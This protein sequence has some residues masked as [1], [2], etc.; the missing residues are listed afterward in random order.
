M[1]IRYFRVMLMLNRAISQEVSL[2]LIWFY[3]KKECK[4]LKVPQGQFWHE[5]INYGVDDEH[6]RVEVHETNVK[7]QWF[8]FKENTTYYHQHYHCGVF[9]IYVI[10]WG[11]V[12]KGYNRLEHHRGGRGVQINFNIGNFLAVMSLLLI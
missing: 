5:H 9:T 8:Q 7:M 11:R 3:M 12:R 2:P 10:H 4:N 1:F 6:D